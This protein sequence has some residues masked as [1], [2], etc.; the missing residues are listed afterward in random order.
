[1]LLTEARRASRIRADGSLMLLAEQ[2]RSQ[3]DRS[4]ID[5]GRQIG[6]WC[7]VRNQPGPCQLQA[8]IG[9]VHV[10]ADSAEETDWSQILAVYDQLLETAQAGGGTQSRRGD[11]RSARSGRCARAGRSVGPGPLLPASR[12]AG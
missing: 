11:R 4:A 8:G 5:E 3:W 10:E 1:L 2:D 6:R 9:A 7:Q 12:H